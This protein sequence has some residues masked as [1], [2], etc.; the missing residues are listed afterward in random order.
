MA[1]LKQLMAV[2]ELQDFALVGGTA[3]AIRY[4]HRLSIDLDL[5]STKDFINYQLV[6]ILEQYFPTF[7]YRSTNNPIGVFGYIDDIKVDFVKHHRFQLIDNI[8]IDDG[9]RFYSDKDIMAMK[10]AA[11]LKRAVKK[12]FWD[13]AEL[14]KHYSLEDVLEAYHKKYPD[15][16][17]AISIPFAITYFEDAEDSE[18]PVS[19]KGQTWQQVKK[20]IQKKVSDYLK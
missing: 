10:V 15:Q 9:I 12:D 3:L 5:F 4:Q 14:L 13:I 1:L 6:S 20:D 19:L 16:R 11:I 8:I 7:S 17:L 18:D 2:P